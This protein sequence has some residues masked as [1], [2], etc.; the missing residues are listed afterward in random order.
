MEKP[1]ILTFQAKGVSMEPLIKEGDLVFVQPLTA[2]TDIRLGDILAYKN[3]DTQENVVHRL[4]EIRNF[5]GKLYYIFQGDFTDKI[6]LT[7]P[8]EDILG[9]VIFLKRSKQLINIEDPWDY[10]LKSIWNCLPVF[11]GLCLFLLKR[12]SLGLKL[13]FAFNL[14]FLISSPQKSLSTVRDKFNQ[15]EE[16]D[17]CGQN[18]DLGLEEWER[19]MVKEYLKEGT[20]ILH[21][22]CGAGR[23]ALALAKLGFK[24]TAIDIAPEMIKKAQSKAKAQG[25]DIHF[26][27]VSASEI[28]FPSCTFDYCL[29]DRILYSFIP[30]RTLRIKTLLRIKRCLKPDGLIFFGAYIANNKFLS[31]NT[32]YRLF[33]KILNCLFPHYFLEPGDIWIRTV[34]PLSK[35]N[36]MCFCHIFSN[37]KEIEKEFKTAGLRL[38]KTNLEGGIHI[39]E[40]ILR[41]KPVHTDNK[42]ED[43]LIID[44]ISGR[45]LRDSAEILKR[46]KQPAMDWS[47]ILDK[48]KKELVFYP[49]YQQIYSLHR[50]Y[51]L[52]DEYVSENFRDAYYTEMAK[53]IYFTQHL[54]ELLKYLDTLCIKILLIKGPSIDILIYPQG[55]LRPRS[56][57]DLVVKEKD[58]FRLE[59]AVKEKG[60]SYLQ[61]LQ[62]YP[63]PEHLNSR[64]YFHKDSSYPALHIHLNPINNL[65]LLITQKNKIDMDKVWLEVIPFK[66]YQNIFCLNPE[67]QIIFMCEHSLK[68]NY[69]NWV[70]LWEI[71]RLIQVYQERIDWEKLMNLSEE[72]NLTR[73]VYLSL[74]LVKEIFSAEVPPQV[75]SCIK[76][77]R[78][79]YLEK[80]F[81]NS[82]LKGKHQKIPLYYAVYLSDQKNLKQRLRFLFRSLFP[83]KMTPAG[84]WERV[85]RASLFL[86]KALIMR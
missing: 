8:F 26:K 33:R 3:K 21:L 48:T 2:N 66:H 80:V 62:V 9:K 19:I 75:F 24:V 45:G 42:E 76:P 82:V 36:S 70:F 52:F 1:N 50:Q 84:Y 83:P 15:K 31:F 44:L 40:L 28:D 32:F 63:I 12:R 57:I 6:D 30:S 56:D 59:E 81:L 49:F 34:S 17:F 7:V 20:S 22:G 65:F 5:K 10:L 14:K 73:I 67:M 58:I 71:S 37:I 55:Y 13:N 41:D 78:L 27:L 4:I 74:Y 72:F 69:Q 29:F 18:A 46:I 43:R 38:I 61:E 23:E 54:T 11:K 39:A 86:P 16:V 53:S 51:N 77:E 47:Y 79:S 25:L 64:Y 85:K 35:M 68:H 60:Y